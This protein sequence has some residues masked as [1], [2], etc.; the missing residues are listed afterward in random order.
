MADCWWANSQA[1]GAKVE[2]T[3]HSV[4][5]WL[6]ARLQ[7]KY[8]GYDESCGPVVLCQRDVQVGRW[9]YEQRV[10]TR[11]QSTL[12]TAVRIIDNRACTLGRVPGRDKL[13]G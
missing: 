10:K 5:D 3:V 11:R 8:K 7:A 12:L 13:V 4:I 1:W 2:L 9:V 6:E